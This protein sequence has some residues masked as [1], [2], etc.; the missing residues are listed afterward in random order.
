[1]NLWFKRIIAQRKGEKEKEN[2]LPTTRLPQ[3]TNYKPQTVSSFSVICVRMEPI[4]NIKHL[5][6]S[7]GQKHVLKDI[8]LEIYPGQVI[9]YIGP[10]GAGKST[11]VKV[12][13]GLLTDYKG[14]VRV[15]GF[16]VKTHTLDVKRHIGYVP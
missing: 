2:Y 11:T 6:K 14:E 16:D 3:T 10:N 7:Y 4:I 12:L 8:N 5:F 9:G 1:M 13:C 15:K